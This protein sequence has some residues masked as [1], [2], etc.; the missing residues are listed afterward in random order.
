[1]SAPT[2]TPHIRGYACHLYLSSVPRSRRMATVRYLPY[3]LL[4]FIRP[5]T[6]TDY[7][8]S[9]TVSINNVL[10]ISEVAH[11]CAFFCCQLNQL[12]DPTAQV[13]AARLCDECATNN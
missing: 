1:M 12:C 7:V 9:P 10:V 13:A 5:Y 11:V 8:R 6:C 4:L 3:G 2:H